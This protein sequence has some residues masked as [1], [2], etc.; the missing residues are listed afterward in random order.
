[1]M[2]IFFYVQHLL[3]IGHFRRAATLA[4]ALAGDGFDLLLVSGGA[5]APG[6]DLGAARL[7]QLPPVRAVDETLRD[8]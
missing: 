1:M 8:L 2:R 5:P 7:Y 6:V 4:R 3:R